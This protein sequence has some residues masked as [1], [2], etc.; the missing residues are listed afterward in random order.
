VLKASEGRTAPDFSL[1][2]LASSPGRMDLVARCIIASL[3]TKKGPR[4]DTTL[5]V[6]LEGDP[7]PPLSLI[8]DG[9]LM[10]N[11]PSSEVKAAQI[12]YDALSGTSIA[13]VRLERK[14]FERVVSDYKSNGYRLFYLHEEGQDSRQVQFGAKTA[15]ILGDQ[16]GI[17]SKSEQLLDGMKIE[18]VSL[19]PYPYLA[20]HCITIINNELDAGKN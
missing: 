9:S 7:N 1:K 20:S 18:R 3:Y 12:V 5:V 10:E 15:H 17:D 4:R 8:F 16:K 6:V 13:G 11:I 19:G 2:S 14:T